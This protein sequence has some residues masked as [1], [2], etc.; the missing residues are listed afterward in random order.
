MALHFN[1]RQSLMALLA[2]VAL[3]A[4]LY[5]A[6]D[7]GARPAPSSPFRH[8]IASGDPDQHSVIL[9]TR[10]TTDRP[11]VP[12]RWEI[13]L[14][15]DFRTVTQKGSSIA[16]RD[17]DHVVKILAAG[18]LPGRHYHYRF[19]ALGQ[20]SP[21]GRTLTLADGQLDRLGIA[22]T[23]CS[24]WV[25]GHFNAYDAIARDPEIDFVLHTGDYIYEYGNDGWG[26]DVIKKTG[27]PHEPAHE[28][29]SL[30]DYRLRHA[31]Y[32]T[33][34]GAQAMHATHPL[35]ACWDDHE[36]ANNPWTGGAQ[37]HQA[38]TEG[39]WADRRAAAIRAYYEWMPV[40]EPGM[41]HSRMEF[42]RSYSFGDLATLVTMETRH[43]GRGEQVDYL[44]YAAGIKT[45]ADA[46]SFDRD[47]IWDPTRTMISP[48]METFLK[49]HLAASIN[50]HQPWRLIGN[51][52]PMART[53]VPDVVALGLIPDPETKADATHAARELAWKGK[54]NLPFYTDTWDG[55]PAAR[56]RFYELAAATG[57]HDL[58]VLTGDSH[59]FWSNVLQ[60]KSGAP[61]GIELG[62]AGITSPGDFVASGF[63][64]TTAEKLDRAFEVHNPEIRWTDNFHQGYVRVALTR[65]AGRAD[66]VAMSTIL[67]RA[68]QP[69]VLRTYH[70]GRTDGHILYRD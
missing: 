45:K 16:H 23:S 62:T 20:T 28:I 55:Y 60:D 51:A 37:N 8:G 11:I 18:L 3:P 54:W 63:D 25:F 4:T 30:A 12:V 52:I 19:F 17:A 64:P 68:Y 24:N 69:H 31:Q 47:V 5:P 67:D 53:L 41:G 61:V 44:K 58:L 2:S 38:A 22:L 34:P 26:A 32:K 10:I 46:E 48:A 49:D 7:A 13:S 33:D 56:E 40:R 70:F 1:R 39:S 43:T 9:W 65:D 14:T 50:N 35:I 29:V 6:A 42:W 57:A 36:S 66:F 59:S 27:R 21:I 15:P